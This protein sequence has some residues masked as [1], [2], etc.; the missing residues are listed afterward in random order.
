MNIP[1]PYLSTQ[2]AHF[3]TGAVSHNQ[4]PPDDLPEIALAG[5]SNVGKSSL[6][7]RLINRRNLARVS[8]TPG[9]TREINFF[10]LGTLAR[11][12]DLPGYGYAAV[13]QHQRLIWDRVAEAY[14]S[15]RRSLRGVILL[16]DLRRG[17]LP[18]DLELI[19]YL[20]QRGIGFLP[21]A[22]KI[23]KLNTNPKNQALR[24]LTQTLQQHTR[25]AISP[26]MPISSL[27]G[28]G[29]PELWQQL[30][31]ILTTP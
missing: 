17:L 3:L 28:T 19:H 7:N 5:R 12:V 13:G 24:T 21:V 31:Q 30:N 14:F 10:T 4:F 6:L 2:P 15:N 18:A 25:L 11:L 1:V 22:T 9:R 29:I 23:D 27:T 8:R 16:I 26:P 20:E